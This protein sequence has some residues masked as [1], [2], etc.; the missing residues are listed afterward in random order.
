MELFRPERTANYTERQKK[1]ITSSGATLT[2]I[3]SIKINNI[4]TSEKH[5]IF[6]HQ[7]G[8]KLVK[9][10]KV[11]FRKSQKLLTERAPRRQPIQ[12]IQ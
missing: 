12:N 8:E 6:L 11:I 4:W 9:S 10:R 2:K 5:K 1:L 7:K 3:H